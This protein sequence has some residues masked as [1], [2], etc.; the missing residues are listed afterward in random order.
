MA[1]SKRRFY[2]VRVRE[3]NGTKVSRTYLATSS[4]DA[5]NQYKGNGSVMYAQKLGRGRLRDDVVAWD[6]CDINRLMADLRSIARAQT[7]RRQEVFRD[8]REHAQEVSG[9]IF[10]GDEIVREI[11]RNRNRKIKG[12]FDDNR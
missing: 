1:R 7:T 8:I 5:A 4:H 9:F 11:K 3:V 2:K 6:S 10:V 12:G